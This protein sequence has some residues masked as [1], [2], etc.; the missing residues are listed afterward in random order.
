MVDK[1]C[2][3][4]PYSVNDTC[5]EFV[6]TYEPALVAVLAQEIDPSQVCPLIR[7]C[8]SSQSK[9]VEIF[10]HAKGD[11]KCPLCLFAVTKLEDLVKNKKSKVSFGFVSVLLLHLVLFFYIVKSRQQFKLLFFE[12]PCENKFPF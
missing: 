10:M 1:A 9:D 4:L 12:I 5:V 3:K 2:S 11:S 7:A 6:N 8:P